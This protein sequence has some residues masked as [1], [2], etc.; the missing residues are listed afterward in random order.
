MKREI[1]DVLPDF[2]G[3]DDFI[4]KVMDTNGDDINKAKASGEAVKAELEKVK[5]ELDEAKDTITKLEESAE[6]VA[7]LKATIEEYKQ[8]ELEAKKAH[9]AEVYEK[10]MQDRFNAIVGDSKFV[11]E[12]TKA[13]AY[14]EFKKAI[15]DTANAGKS[16]KDIYSELVKDKS[17]WFVG[18]AGFANMTGVDVI[19]NSLIDAE[20]FKAMPLIQQMAFANEHPKEYAEMSKMLK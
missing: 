15:S 11:N 8:K 20:K 18:K 3:K 5:A 2:D 1:F 4:K 16:D 7:G 17:D 9:E 14:D 19:D 6:D 13:G 12:F 10:N